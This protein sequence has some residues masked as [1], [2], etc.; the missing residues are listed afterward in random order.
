LIQGAAGWNRVRR[1]TRWR[2]SEFT[3]RAKEE[4]KLAPEFAADELACELHLTAPAAAG[5]M[6]NAEIEDPGS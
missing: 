1:I 5:Q 3:A 4:E 2:G 6:E